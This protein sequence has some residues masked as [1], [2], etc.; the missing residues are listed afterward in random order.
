MQYFDHLLDY[1]D[2]IKPSRYFDHL[3]GDV[4]LGTGE[5]LPGQSIQQREA[6]RPTGEV[7][8]P[9]LPIPAADVDNYLLSLNKNRDKAA[10]IV[11]MAKLHGV[12]ESSIIEKYDD[13]NELKDQPEPYK[14]LPHLAMTGGMLMAPV[15][16]AATSVP[17][18][19]YL[20]W[21]AAF[22]VEEEVNRHVRSAVEGKPLAE[23]KPYGLMDLAPEDADDLTKTLLTTLDIIAK[24]KAMHLGYKGLQPSWDHLTRTTIEEHGLPRRVYVDPTVYDNFKKGIS[25]QEETDLIRSL[26][27]TG[28]ELRAAKHGG[29]QVDFPTERLIT[30]ADRPWYARFKRALSISPYSETKALLGE[31]GR[32]ITPVAGLIGEEAAPGETAGPA[33]TPTTPAPSAPTVSASVPARYEPMFERVVETTGVPRDLF[34]RLVRAE[35]G[36][37]PAVPSPAGAVGLTQLMPGTAKDMGVLDRTDPYD[38]LKGGAKYFKQQLERYNGD[39]TRA[40][41]AYNWGPLNADR[42]NGNPDSL[43]EETRV[44][45]ERI[46]G[47]QQG[48]RE[49]FRQ[50]IETDERLTPELRK[51]YL[52][53]VDTIA[54][55][56]AK[57]TGADPEDWWGLYEDALLAEPQ[58]VSG[59]KQMSVPEELA[60][61]ETPEFKQWFGDSK[62][63]DRAGNPLVVYHGT[64]KGNFDSFDPEK[65]KENFKESFGFHFTSDPTVAGIYSGIATRS[66]DPSIYPTYLQIDNP[67]VLDSGFKSPSS[68]LD[69][70]R[71][72]FIKEIVESRRAGKPFDGI[73][74]KS[75]SGQT[76]FVAFSPTQIKSV[77]NRG[78][79][80]KSDPNILQEQQFD[81]APGYP[82]SDAILDSITRPAQPPR[83]LLNA[84]DVDALSNLVDKQLD[85]DYPIVEGETDAEATTRKYRREGE[86]HGQLVT[87]LEV[88]KRITTPL[89]L[90][91]RGRGLGEDSGRDPRRDQL[92]P[93]TTRILAKAFR[94]DLV[95]KGY[96]DI[97]G[98]T[99]LTTAD[100]AHIA[101]ALRDPRTESAHWIF[102]KEERVIGAF[103]V[104][105]GVP[106]MTAVYPEG[107]PG[108]I[109][110]LINKLQP[111]C[112][113]VIHNH[114]SGDP[115]PSVQ[116]IEVTRTIEKDFPGKAR[117]HII[118]NSGKYA[119]MRVEDL[120]S[121]A[122]PAYVPI[123]KLDV[124]KNWK[125]LL[126][127]PSV[128]HPLNNLVIE[129]VER[130]AQIAKAL[131]GENAPHVLIYR[132]ANGKIRGIE[133]IPV[134]QL[135]ETA[136]SV[137]GKWIR[138]RLI[139]FGATQAIL[140]VPEESVYKGNFEAL[141]E[142]YN[143]GHL[144]EVVDGDGNSLHTQ[145][146]GGVH[147]WDTRRSQGYW[148]GAKIKD[149]PRQL[150]TE[151]QIPYDVE[152]EPVSIEAMDSFAQLEQEAA[153]RAHEVIEKKIGRERAILE[154]QLKKEAAAIVDEDLVQQA[155][156]TII[157]HRGISPKWLEK[158]GYGKDMIVNLKA[159]DRRLVTKSGQAKPDELAMDTGYFD[160]ADSMLEAIING[161]SRAEAIRRVS[162]ALAKESQTKRE[163]NQAE[164]YYELLNAEI[165]I[166]KE[167]TAKDT[168]AWANKPT[169]GLKEYIDK[170]LASSTIEETETVTEYDA[171]KAAMKKAQ[172]HARIA[173]NAGRKDIALANKVRERELLQAWKTK[174]EARKV[175]ERL[176]KRLQK[177][178]RI[179]ASELKGIKP[180][181][182]DVI[183][184]ILA[185]YQTQLKFRYQ[186]P[187]GATH[188]AFLQHMD[189]TGDLTVHDPDRIREMAAKPWKDLTI[190]E[191]R[192]IAGAVDEVIF[193]AKREGKIVKG[194]KKIDLEATVKSLVAKIYET[195]PR[196]ATPPPTHLD[197]LEVRDE[198]GTTS[199]S[200]Y[201]Q[202]VESLK[203]IEF[204]LRDLDGFEEMGPLWTEIFKPIADA[205]ADELILIAE[206][207]A[208]IETVKSEFEERTGEKLSKWLSEKVGVPGIE[209]VFSRQVWLATHLNAGNEGNLKALR[210]TF[211]QEQID[212]VIESF[213]P[214]E[215][216]L[217]DDIFDLVSSLWDRLEA[218]HRAMTGARLKKVEGKYYPIALDP[219]ASWRA[220]KI[221]ADETQKDL[222]QNTFSHPSMKK[223]FEYER[224]GTKLNLRLDLSPLFQ[225]L[226][227]VVHRV[228]YAEAVRNVQKIITH[229]DFREAVEATRGKAF[230]DQFMPWLQYVAN[231]KKDMSN[232][233]WDQGAD[234]LRRNT[235]LNM[236]GF[237]FG[238]VIKS[239]FDWTVPVT[240]LGFMSTAT[241]G[242][243]SYMMHPREIEAFVNSLSPEMANFQKSFDREMSAV[244]SRLVPT[245]DSKAQR[246]VEW[247]FAMLGMVERVN[248]YPVWLEAYSQAY[249][250]RGRWEGK[251]MSQE[252][253]A[254]WADSIVRRTKAMASPKDLPAIMRGRGMMRLMTMFYTESSKIHNLMGEFW[255]RARR[256]PTYGY[257]DYARAF[258]WIM[259]VGPA[260]TSVAYELMTK[261]RMPSPKEAGADIASFYFGR[262]PFVRDI[263]NAVLTGFGYTPTPAAKGPQEAYAFISS[264]N[265]A[266]QG[267]LVRPEQK[268]MALV[269]GL[270]AFAL[271]NLGPWGGYPTRQMTTFLKGLMDL[272]TGR[273]QTPLSLIDRSAENKRRQDLKRR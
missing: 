11:A 82:T 204:M 254:L 78:T 236:L 108:Y 153:R 240:E 255:K 159:V 30:I 257:W 273:S 192:E 193:H 74:V 132:A 168:R 148:Q 173:Y 5:E 37:Q 77:F 194:D 260:M 164:T 158:A 2:D 93:P 214:D 124:P 144:L 141:Q 22:A 53:D 212:S 72:T 56:W 229:K 246:A 90:P 145:L 235:T 220:E 266:L 206:K 251:R 49:K 134:G 16:A 9:G 42:W 205:E 203:K 250:G 221:K 147:P 146:G 58:Q 186:N 24:G 201:A 122:S 213:N 169:P 121:Y 163:L 66:N 81:L 112:I 86:R 170:H 258:M 269:H 54:E 135:A 181:Y 228:A 249:E 165:A 270:D 167:L 21:P 210:S 44:Y 171:L 67:L 243:R 182:R 79:W 271:L 241:H 136:K 73:V 59:G 130:T 161:T 101:Q 137:N 63:V 189:D 131:L 200:L 208:M 26:G 109:Q 227:D 207:M 91:E 69:L 104:T 60:R 15:M 114:P 183:H 218:T 139:A 174:L 191:L 140:Y 209:K 65:I 96:V 62:V 116:D 211:T 166:L 34:A 27:L 4:K 43:P 36:W 25:T 107:G 133:E 233:V 252:K 125:D 103:G 111:D 265:K 1:A 55:T 178:V 138:E 38:N 230:Y 84:S 110:D 88:A 267:K 234:K 219:E 238:T 268:T 40:L 202:Y 224:K 247:A 195:A 231:P 217:V 123:E 94:D 71:A 232:S 113:D 18:W 248:R 185:P 92:T 105:L 99:V 76:D 75:Q 179:P 6:P 19:K 128:P 180:E 259:I 50:T 51:Q 12:P 156:A 64:G 127:S 198:G 31:G 20:I 32:K 3:F 184:V 80:S 175:V 41:V 142:L 244:Y 95:K 119:V 52:N 237:A 215:L 152:P 126:L 151:D 8:I 149:L 33:P 115:T 45:L 85:E 187:S 35:S 256:D 97:I 264:I 245:S 177:A 7:F 87:G 120:G 106:G 46:L 23:T 225:H 196:G 14:F 70:D 143:D 188:A 226:E 272:G 190:P 172:T 100:V 162:S 129:S 155:M 261:G 29:F 47:A 28:E 160:G 98:K 199:P 239:L 157:G 83:S 197:I 223:G 150:L 118:I 68:L 17:L 13:L 176:T 263:A 61:T 89:A 117:S 48:T 216:K 10:N 57:V 253:A 39:Q 102:I 154:N 242:V 222:F 262:F